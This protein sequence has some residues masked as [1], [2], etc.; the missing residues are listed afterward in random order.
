M[1]DTWTL[2]GDPSVMV[3]TDTPG[4]MTVSHVSKTPLSTTKINVS[5]NVKDALVCLSKDGVILGTGISN[6]TTAEIT[7][8][9]AVAGIIDVVATA[10]NKMPYAGTISVDGTVGVDELTANHLQIYPVPASNTITIT[11]ELTNAGKIKLAVY[12]NL[13]QE[14]LMIAN[15]STA[16]GSFT[17][18]IDVSALPAGVYFCKLETGISTEIQRVIIQH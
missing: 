1:T 12:N 17:K 11:G 4:P 7:I 5:C 13:G 9:A 3:F 18:T 8:P 6:G 16:A 14:M 15:E 2:F 10:Y